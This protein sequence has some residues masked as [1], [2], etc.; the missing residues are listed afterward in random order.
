MPC[1]PEFRST[2]R[3]SG[4]YIVSKTRL[5]FHRDAG[6]SRSKWFPVNP[7]IGGT[8]TQTPNE[9]PDSTT[10]DTGFRWDPTG[11][12]WIYNINTKASPVN[13]AN[14]TYTFQITLNDGSV[15]QFRFGLR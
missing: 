6:S 10:P 3:S 5:C 2:A 7:V 14:R 11:Q 1:R 15:I 12:Q 8:V 4:I 13:V 9:V